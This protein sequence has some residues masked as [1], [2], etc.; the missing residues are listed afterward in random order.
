M[1]HTGSYAMTTD[2]IASAPTPSRSRTTWFL[3]T[4]SVSP[5]S[6]CASVSPTQRITLS[7]AASAAVRRSFTVLSVSPKYCLRSLCP[8]T[9]Y[10]TPHSTSIS[11][12]IS[13][14]NA[15]DLAQCTFCAP[16]RTD[17]PETASRMAK[18]STNGTHKTTSHDADGYLLAISAARAR[19]SDGVLFIFQFPAIIYFP[20]LIPIFS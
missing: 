4:V 17:V 20:I 19:A 8:I 15:P 12:D 11:A 2:F 6:R 3:T 13:P 1:A 5:A 10:S 9:T 14:V 16:I 7:P 18:R